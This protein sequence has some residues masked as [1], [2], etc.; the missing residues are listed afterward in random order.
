MTR[1][2]NR[3]LSPYKNGVQVYERMLEE[4]NKEDP[5]TYGQYGFREIDEPDPAF[6]GKTVPFFSGSLTNIIRELTGYTGQYSAILDI[7][8]RQLRCVQ[9]TDKGGSGR[10]S[11]FYLLRHPDEAD[12][13]GELPRGYGSNR[14]NQPRTRQTQQ[15]IDIGIL[16][17][18]MRDIQ[19]EVSQQQNTIVQLTLWV[20]QIADHVGLSDSEPQPW[21]TK[22]ALQD[23]VKEGDGGQEIHAQEGTE[24]ESGT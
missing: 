9:S 19:K 24:T 18:L 7:L 8:Q 2:L 23:L 17:E 11:E 5:V 4:A 21:D 15:G 3:N 13:V 10:G 1:G 6:E 22:R 14:P 20:K 16:R 12:D